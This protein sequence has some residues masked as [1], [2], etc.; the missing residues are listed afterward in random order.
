MKLLVALLVMVAG[1][2]G[3]KS[4]TGPLDPG[5]P[6]FV[7]LQSDAG[8]NIGEGKSYEYTTANAIINIQSGGVDLEITIQGDES[9]TGAF[10]IPSSTGQLAVGT[11][12]KLTRYVGSSTQPSMDWYGEGR[13]CGALT[14]TLTIAVFTLMV[15]S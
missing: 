11:Y 8:D 9:W 10:H 3:D 14:G 1:C 12:D 4:V 5:F 7:K 15:S 13:G 6:S 2:A